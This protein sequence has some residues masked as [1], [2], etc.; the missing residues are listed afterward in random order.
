MVVGLSSIFDLDTSLTV[1]GS[2][3]YANYRQMAPHR[4]VTGQTAFSTGPINFRF[5]TS[6]SVYIVPNRSYIRMRIKLGNRDPVTGVPTPITFANRIAPNINLGHHLFQ[7]CEWRIGDK[8]VSRISDFVPQVGALHQ[9]LNTS[10]NWRETTGRATNYSNY[11]FVQRQTDIVKDA[12]YLL[13]ETLAT[14][15]SNLYTDALRIL[16][17]THVDAIVSFPANGNGLLTFTTHDPAAF[18]DAQSDLARPAFAGRVGQII[19]IGKQPHPTQQYIIAG[20][21]VRVAV[22]AADTPFMRLALQRPA[23]ATYLNAGLDVPIARTNYL[24]EVR[25][26]E[27]TKP[28]ARGAGAFELCFQ[29]PLS[30]WDYEKG[31]PGADHT[32]MLNPVPQDVLKRA[33]IQSAGA[34]IP[35]ANIYFEVESMY[36][37]TYQITGPP[38]TSTEFLI[39]LETIRL[40]TD[41]TIGASPGS[42]TQKIFD[43][44]PSTYA[45]AVCYQDQ[46]VGGADTRLSSAQFRFFNADLGYEATNA[47]KRFYIQYAGQQFPSPDADPNLTVIDNE[48]GNKDYTTERY[49]QTMI[50]SGQYYQLGES[51]QEFRER[52]PFYY[53]LVPR[54]NTDKSTR[55]QINQMFQ[56]TNAATTAQLGPALA[57]LKLCLF[58]LSRQVAVIT[59]DGGNVTKVSLQDQ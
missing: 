59:L 15:L 45:L 5:Q 43:V 52:G 12:P 6:S 27:F 48:T 40:Q 13:G 44:S 24:R 3:A 26:I 20:E 42:L 10:K 46:R 57:S 56:E 55:V 8:T 41:N 34:D 30:I 1:A 9:R 29:L 23:N 14:P 25:F 47:L 21:P 37:V 28:E 4:D 53:F 35:S 51:I 32:L 11:S 54:D 18:G 36:L 50:E 39:D 33:I 19:E 31:I 2:S 58:D 16:F 7:N 49:M 22:G 38:V 17:E